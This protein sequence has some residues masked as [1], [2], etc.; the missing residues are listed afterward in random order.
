MIGAIQNGVASTISSMQSGI[1]LVNEGAQ[2]ASGAE[3]TIAQ[4]VH[5]IDEVALMVG[6]I[7]NAL[8]EQ[9]NGS[10][11]IANQVQHIAS[12]AQQNIG[13]AKETEQSAVRLN[14]LS[15]D[16]QDMVNRFTV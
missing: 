13:A 5:K 10:E 8:S 1:G 2:L 9:R 3:A 6:E 4:V 12:M 14:E 11:Q 7:S 15:L 16:M